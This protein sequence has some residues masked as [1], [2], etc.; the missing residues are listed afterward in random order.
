MDGKLALTTG[1]GFF[2]GKYNGRKE[3]QVCVQ[4]QILMKYTFEN[5]GSRADG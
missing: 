1:I 5:K 4:E 3:K 2:L